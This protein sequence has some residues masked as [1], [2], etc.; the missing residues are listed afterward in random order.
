[1]MVDLSQ[2]GWNTEMGMPLLTKIKDDLKTAMRNKDE[3]VKSAIRMIMGEFPRLTVPIT[4][5]SGKKTTRV[6]SAEEITDEDIQNIVRGL[7]KSEKTV[8]EAKNETSNAYIDL[9]N[10]YL[11]KMAAKED[12]LAWIAANDL[13][14]FKSP[15]Q[16]I[17]PIMKH[18]GK[19]ADGNM[20]KEILKSL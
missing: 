3:G 7:V 19:R 10:R 6:K 12:I 9:L 11:P 2:Y 1:M 8:L 17:G 5:E 20:V 13:S 16:A 4:L 18:F 14:Q 15:M